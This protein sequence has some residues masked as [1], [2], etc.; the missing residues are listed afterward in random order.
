VEEEEEGIEKGKKWKNKKIKIKPQI[1]IF[2][3]G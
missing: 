3:M 1:S 2:F